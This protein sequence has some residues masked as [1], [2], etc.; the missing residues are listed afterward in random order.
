MTARLTGQVALVTG[1]AG[2]IGRAVVE[3]FVEE[4]C[5][6]AVLD[7]DAAVRQELEERR[8]DRVA[9]TVGDVRS[10]ADLRR[11]VDD[12]LGRFGRLDTL[13]ANAGIWDYDRRLDEYET[14]GR[15]QS[16][17]TEVFGVNVLGVLL[18]AAA[19]RPAL[20][21][22]SGSIVV[23]SSPSGRYAGGGGPV[24]VASKHA[25][26]GLVL[27]L[28]YELAPEIRVNAVAPGATLTGLAG[29]RALELEGRRLEDEPAFAET[30]ARRLPLGAVAR[31]ADHASL[32][33]L[34]ASAAE[35]G[36]MTGAV[37][38]SDGGMAVRGGGR[39]A[40]ETRRAA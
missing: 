22:A 23:T 33:V 1:G 11:A 36:F 19:A 13:V 27:Q 34:L 28:A 5:R 12:A 38:P 39:R 32:Y 21:A 4:G 16:T 3:R 17:F 25:V 24:Y 7:R 20:R 40:R 35:S 2:G 14:D 10:P 9:V 31:P 15:L 26:E 18:A 29:P 30:L 8:G 37:V 6:V